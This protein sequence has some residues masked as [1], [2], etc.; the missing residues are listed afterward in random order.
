MNFLPFFLP[1][2]LIHLDN[3]GKGLMAGGETHEDFP[4]QSL[5]DIIKQP[6]LNFLSTL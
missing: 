6:H 5:F 4:F 1:S 2:V 3:E